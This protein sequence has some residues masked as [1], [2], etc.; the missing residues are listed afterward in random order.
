MKGQL[1]RAQVV[2]LVAS[3]AVIIG[4]WSGLRLLP[5]PGVSADAEWIALKAARESLR[6][7]TDSAREEWRRKTAALAEPK[8]TVSQLAEFSRSLPAGWRWQQQ[9]HTASI[10]RAETPFAQWTEILALLTRL[11]RTPGLT[12]VKVELQAV[13]AGGDRHFAAIAVD[14][15]IAAETNGNPERAAFLSP[16]PVSRLSGGPG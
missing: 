14:L 16:F 4:V 11:E 2:R 5:A 1:T 6:E 7:A 10:T 15:R 3:V 13:G 8:W 12:V 9:T